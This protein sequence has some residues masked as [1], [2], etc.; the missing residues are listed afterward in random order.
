MLNSGPKIFAQMNCQNN[1][2]PFIFAIQ[3][4]ILMINFSDFNV[5]YLFKTS[6]RVKRNGCVEPLSVLEDIQGQ[7]NLGG[8]PLL[9][10]PEQRTL[11]IEP[12]TDFLKKN[13]L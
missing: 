6:I 2:K 9:L 7:G 1:R 3:Y 12:K 5:I 4:Q 11:K 8:L 13:R 10:N